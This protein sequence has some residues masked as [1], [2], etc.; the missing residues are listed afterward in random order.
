MSRTDGQT[1][2][3]GFIGP[4]VGVAG[5]INIW[6]IALKSILNLGFLIAINHPNM[7]TKIQVDQVAIT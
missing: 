5:P 3:A 2:G 7:K 6:R 4:A 1:D